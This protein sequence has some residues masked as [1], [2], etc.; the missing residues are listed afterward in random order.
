MVATRIFVGSFERLNPGILFGEWVKDFNYEEPFSS[1]HCLEIIRKEEGPFCLAI[2]VLNEM[3][4]K[5][6]SEL[7]KLVMSSRTI[8]F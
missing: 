7:K 2:D 4:Q 1:I 3:P 6:C 5:A 8:V